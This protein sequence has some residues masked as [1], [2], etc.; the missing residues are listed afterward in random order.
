MTD[1]IRHLSRLEL[2]LA[3][4]RLDA[5]VSAI[6]GPPVGAIIGEAP[7]PNTSPKLPMFPLPSRSAGGRLLG[8]AGIPVEDYLGRLARR[9]LFAELGPWSTRTARL[10]AFQIFWW[11]RNMA[12]GIRRVLLLGGRVGAAFGLAEFWRPLKLERDLVLVAIPHPSGKNRVYND[13][14]V[15]RRAGSEVRWAAGMRRTRP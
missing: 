1:R 7:G 11:L 12:T 2:R 5:D 6:S 13:P 3:A 14:D 9:N 10:Q 8:Y 15:C 4:T